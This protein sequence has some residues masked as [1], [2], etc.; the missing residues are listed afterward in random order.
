MIG[1]QL[2]KW[3]CTPQIKPPPESSRPASGGYW[4]CL[5]QLDPRGWSPRQMGL[6][7]ESCWILWCRS[8]F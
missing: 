5:R 4:F 1:Y 7:D 6:D 2:T 8:S 3:N